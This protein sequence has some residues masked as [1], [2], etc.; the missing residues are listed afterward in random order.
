MFF[1][2][3]LSQSRKDFLSVNGKIPLLH[4]NIHLKEI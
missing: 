1:S 3:N 2:Q 4:E